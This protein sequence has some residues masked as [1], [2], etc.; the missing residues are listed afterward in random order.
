MNSRLFLLPLVASFLAACSTEPEREADLG[1]AAI[2]EA[3]A[4]SQE[5]F[6][7]QT[8]ELDPL[9]TGPVPG[10]PTSGSVVLDASTGKL[11]VVIV[12]DLFP[13]FFDTKIERT[14]ADTCGVKHYLGVSDQHPDWRDTSWTVHLEDRTASHCSGEAGSH[15]VLDTVR[16]DGLRTHSVLSVKKM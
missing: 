15:A 14:W 4:G 2:T 7:V 11:T 16:R 5:L 6:R 13:S 10:E 9:V 3:T 12:F 8:F 1:A